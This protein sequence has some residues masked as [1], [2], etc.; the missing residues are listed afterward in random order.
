MRPQARRIII[1]A[2]FLRPYAHAPGSCSTRPQARWLQAA[3]EWPLRRACRLPVER[4][5]WDEGFD[6]RNFYHLLGAET[7]IEAWAAI[8]FA[9]TLPADADAMIAAAF[10][11]A[12]V[13]S[14]ELAPSV[15]AAL[16]RA[17]IPVIDARAATLRFLDDLLIAWRSNHAE[18]QQR[19]SEYR[20]DEDIAWRQAGLIR[21]K[22][23]WL[24]SLAVP[25]GSALLIGQVGS[26]ASLINRRTGH[27]LGFDDYI[28]QLFAMAEKHDTVLYK[29][30][31]YADG[32]GRSESVARRFKS[33]RPVRDNVYRLMSQ[34]GLQ[35]VYAISSGCVIE[36]PY[37]G[38]HGQHFYEPVPELD[39]DG[40]DPHG[41]FPAMSLD[42]TWLEPAFWRDVL[43][44]LTEVHSGGE[45]PAPYRSHRIRRSLNADW[46][47]M[48]MDEVVATA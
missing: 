44:P 45:A 35:A 11:D 4:I 31:P 20:F 37:F 32:S 14:Y 25:D 13:I 17:G 18:V 16:G 23:A 2:D 46:G 5:A 30:H 47:F 1:A 28:E 40:R 36:A 42:Q 29:A 27:L 7:G 12:I 43:A 8:H 19:L 15:V 48:P 34:P 6:T 39:A 10:A 24:P 41:F 26:D 9:R 33:F 22:A 3:L 21:A 38:K